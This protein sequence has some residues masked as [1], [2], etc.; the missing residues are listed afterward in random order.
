MQRKSERRLSLRRVGKKG[1]RREGQG[2]Q[3]MRFVCIFK[4]CTI[5]Q[6]FR[7]AELLCVYG[8][9]LARPDG[10][11]LGGLFHPKS[12]IFRTER[13]GISGKTIPSPVSSSSKAFVQFLYFFLCLLRGFLNR[14]QR[15]SPPGVVTRCCE[16]RLERLCMG[17][18]DVVSRVSDGGQVAGGLSCRKMLMFASL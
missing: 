5:V 17:C 3:K 4:V 9:A 12:C 13:C 1:I 7:I 2:C 8:S 10:W 15:Q 16:D 18:F 14:D 6:F 11:I